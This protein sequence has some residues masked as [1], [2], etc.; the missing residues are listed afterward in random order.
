MS[1]GDVGVLLGALGSVGALLIAYL[2]YRQSNKK[3]KQQI[4]ADSIKTA[5]TIALTPLQDSLNSAGTRTAVLETKVDML[6]S[7][8]QKD[9]AKL[10][11][12]PDP[13]RA[14]IDYLMDKI[15]HDQSLTPHEEND[16]REILKTIMNYEPGHSPDPGFPIRD[17]EQTQA[18]FLLRS[19]DYVPIRGSK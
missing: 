8:L 15:I 7:N 16:L 9:M 17:G 5:I 19:L 12:S 13:R 18:A 11:H 1:P 10:L 4:D 14:H 6:W 2:A 3:D